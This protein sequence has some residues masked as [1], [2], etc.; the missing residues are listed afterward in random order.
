[1]TVDT[2]NPGLKL[3]VINPE[4]AKFNIKL[5]AFCYYFLIRI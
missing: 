5:T 3:E 2:N 1:M 4:S